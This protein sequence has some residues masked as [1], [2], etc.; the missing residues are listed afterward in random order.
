[1]LSHVDGRSTP[2][3]KITPQLDSRGEVTIANVPTTHVSLAYMKF[4]SYN[5]G[6][7]VRNSMN[8]QYS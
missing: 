8:T 3:S 5:D 2:E 6:D 4:R 1:M 7:A